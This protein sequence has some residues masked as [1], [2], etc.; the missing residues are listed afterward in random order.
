MTPAPLE[1]AENTSSS[2]IARV[3]KRN[4]DAWQRFTKLYGPLVYGWARRA[5]LQD[6]DAA[7]VTQDVFRAIAASIDSFQAGANTSLRG[8]MWGITRNKLHDHF[9]RRRA[10]PASPG[11]TDA[12]EQLQQLDDASP[13][14]LSDV[15]PERSLLHRA[16]D[17]IR[18]DFDERTWQA[19]WRLAVGNESAAEIGSDLAMTPKAV[20]QAKYRVL[21]RL[22]SELEGQL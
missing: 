8:W 17:L 9:R 19:F 20:R 13:D 4:A 1:S 2:L 5:G 6:A 16:L 7:D 14:E 21:R 18:G 22:R 11:G 3:R 10:Q 12:Y 15:D